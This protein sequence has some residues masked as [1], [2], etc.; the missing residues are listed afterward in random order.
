VG[1]D[2]DKGLEVEDEVYCTMRRVQQTLA[3]GTRRA[4]VREEEEEE[5]EEEEP[6]CVAS[7]AVLATYTRAMKVYPTTLLR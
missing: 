4:R 3:E 7:G 5:E 2:E 6:C 1:N